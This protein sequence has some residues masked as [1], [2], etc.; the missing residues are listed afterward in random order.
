MT[1]LAAGPR[2]RG[3][4]GRG[5]YDGDVFSPLE[6][7]RPGVLW[8]ATYPI[9]Y[10]GTHFDAR[11]AVVKL[12]DGRLLL[13]SP[14]P[15]DER[16]AAEVAALGEVAFIVA[17]GN[18]HHVH[19]ARCQQA[20]PAAETWICLGV[21]RKQPSLKYDGVLSDEA[22]AGWAADIDQVV[23]R[24]RIMAEVIMLHRPSRTLLLV[25][26]IENYGDYTPGVHWLLR[27]Y[28][29]LLGMWNRPLPA[30][31][32]RFGWRDRDAVRSALERVLA[33]DFERIVL[34][35][36]ALVDDNAKDVARRAWKA[37]T[38]SGAAQRGGG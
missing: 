26:L 29:K 36:G 24:G 30:P 27:A 6:E 22:P 35:H 11:M 19:V 31:E 5:R 3:T 16:A 18:F 38:G 28:W 21:E 2:G 23:V 32:Y 8:V 10:G 33:W 13:H 15:M 12:E 14:G 4:G 9:R 20:F 37:V 17:P 25:D 34:A 1:P 7:L